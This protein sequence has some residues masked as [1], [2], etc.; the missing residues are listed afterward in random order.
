MWDKVF[1]IALIW[2]ALQIPLGLLAGGFIRVGSTDPAQ[3]KPSG[4]KRPNLRPR[5]AGHTKLAR[6]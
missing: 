5:K 3:I 2:L 6:A 1:V 4:V